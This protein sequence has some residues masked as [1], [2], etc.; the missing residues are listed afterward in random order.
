MFLT[1]NGKKI[2]DQKTKET[3]ERIG[4]TFSPI[5][6]EEK[7]LYTKFFIV[8]GMNCQNCVKKITISIDNLIFVKIDLIT[9]Q[10]K[11]SFKEKFEEKKV[12]D[13]FFRLLDSQFRKK[14]SQ[15]DK[16]MN[17]KK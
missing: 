7:D 5:I 9:K 14:Y 8:D 16:K 2:D 4:F 3:V 10:L 15:M 12:I 6:K 17:L 13:I 11:V 1:R